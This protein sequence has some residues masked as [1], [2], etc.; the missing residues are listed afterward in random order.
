MINTR[1]NYAEMY[2][3]KMDTATIK[4]IAEMVGF[5]NSGYFIKVFKSKFGV[6]PETY[7][8]M[9]LGK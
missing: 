5:S 6:T 8:D 3:R 2:L 4:Q 7:R 1:L 9:H